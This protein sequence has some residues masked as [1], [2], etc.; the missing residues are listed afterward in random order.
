M[1][2]VDPGTASGLPQGDLGLLRS[3]VAQ[4]VASPTPRHGPLKRSTE[5]AQDV[6]P[7]LY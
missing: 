4:H 3:E 2:T 5:P 6:S 1:S 7:F